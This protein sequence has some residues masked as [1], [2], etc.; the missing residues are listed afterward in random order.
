V[1]FGGQLPVALTV[2]QVKNAKPGDKLT[3]GG[4]LRLDIDARGG[5][6]W[7]FRFKSPVTGKERYMGW[8]LPPMLAWRRPAKRQKKPAA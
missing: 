2:L 1:G 7:V 8:D 6:S 4:G 5:R 3:D